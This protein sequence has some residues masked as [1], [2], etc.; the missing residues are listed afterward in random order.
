M[1]KLGGSREATVDFNFTFCIL[2]RKKTE[3]FDTV[4]SF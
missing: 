1:K 4:I 3:R 2:G